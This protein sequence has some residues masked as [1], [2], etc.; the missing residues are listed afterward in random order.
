MKFKKNEFSLYGKTTP[1]G[2]K[3]EE[4]DFYWLEN[5]FLLKLFPSNFN[6]GFQ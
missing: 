3:T 5:V 6:N 4:N 1:S 2:K